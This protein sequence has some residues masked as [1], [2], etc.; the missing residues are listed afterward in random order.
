MKRYSINPDLAWRIIENEAVILK[1]KNTTYYSLDPVG[2]YIWQQIESSPTFDEI[3][4]RLTKD[5]DVSR[6]RAAEDLDELLS[7][8][9]EELI[10]EV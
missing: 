4:D 6:E 2:T 5:Y 8:L 3:L 1:I 10:L 9:R 7:D